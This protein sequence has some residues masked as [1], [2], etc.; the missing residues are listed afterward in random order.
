MFELLTASGLGQ[1]YQIDPGAGV[2]VRS[3]G[4]E[5]RYRYLDTPAV[6]ERLVDY[7]DARVTKVT[8]R[9]PA[10]HCLA[11]VWL[12]EN[13]FRMK[14]GIGRSQADFLKREVSI[15]FATPEATLSVVAGLLAALGY[16]PDLNLADLDKPAETPIQRRLWL[17]IAV[18]G[19]AFGN[20]M[21]L[22]IAG[23]L[24]LDAFSG[25]GLRT[26]A[27]W[28]SLALAVPVAAFSA[29]D[30]WKLAWLGLRRR[31]LTIE[32]PIAAGIVALFAQSTWEI[33]TGRGEG[34]FDSLAGLVFF[35]LCGKLFQQKTYHRL[36][37]DRDYR[38]F[39]P[40]SATRRTA[41][42]EES[43]S[44][45]QLAVG[46]RLLVR[47]GEL[48]PAD[49][50]LR[51]GEALIDYS[52]VTG[53]SEPIEKEAGDYLYAGGRQAGGTIEIETIEPP[54][55]S[56]LARLWDQ[57]AFRKERAGTFDSLTNRYSERFTRLVLGIAVGA[58]LYWAAMDP[59]KAVK[60]FTSVLIVACP[61]ALA[62]AAPFTLGTAMRALG[63]REV[64][65]K[66][67]Q[68]IE[69]LA[70]ADTIVFDK[71]GTLTR[72]GGAGVEFEGAP[73]SA[74]E[75]GWVQ[76]VARHSTHPCSVRITEALA[77]TVAKEARR[78]EAWRER[79]FLEVPGCGVEATVEGHEVW[80]GSG[81]WLAQRG[82]RVLPQAS[83]GGQRGR[84]SPE[85]PG[86]LA[87]NRSGEAPERTGEG[88]CPTQN[89]TRAGGFGTAVH[90]AID[91]RHRGCFVLANAL[92]PGVERM[93]ERLGHTYRLVL[94]SGDHPREEALYRRLFPEGAPLHFE[95]TPH[96]KLGLI[97]TLQ[98]W[99]RKVAMVGD[100]LNDAGALRQ[101]EAGLAVVEKISAFSP[102]SDVIVPGAQVAQLDRIF[103]FCRRTARVVRAGFGLSAAYN[104]VGIG[105][106]AAGLLSP[107]VCA[108]LMPLS[109]I[110]VVAFACAATEWA[111]RRA[112]LAAP[113][114]E[115]R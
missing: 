110:S 60:A 28:I 94:L 111:A 98:H 88:A 90:L 13:L 49:A 93:L 74:E 54:S 87:R 1:F 78:S 64:F 14:P 76:A 46:D 27:G 65:V 107:V 83:L 79:S 52:F 31:M 106:A 97:R 112:G 16:E 34:Y 109:S 104:A 103:D 11:C 99:G 96:G 101:S 115:A 25:P 35:L 4:A 15:S 37:F 100:G 42:G 32:V 3:E 5:D 77:E 33:V 105:I 58:A 70:A 85:K 113:G 20:S 2:R 36:S 6:R 56:Y 10:M 39:F 68:A 23:Y 57:E 82:V 69:A 53:E 63:R 19:F 21:L 45:A 84:R 50:R 73:L 108:I 12:L 38:A 26:L 81:T 86:L 61:C 9:V 24:G 44:I 55:Q 51:S 59:S 48:V 67:G 71:T 72:A 95:Q 43:I 75:A 22:S 66:N 40:L 8:F 62:L 102:A 30:Y 114:R 7:S 89:Q 80:L 18:A 29:G 91:G 92:R 41:A 47:H 17:Q